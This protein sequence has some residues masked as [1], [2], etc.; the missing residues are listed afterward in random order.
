MSSPGILI[1][2]YAEREDAAKA[3]RLLRSSLFRR[4]RLLHRRADG[5]FD[6]DDRY[7]R[8]RFLAPTIGA[9]VGL[10][11]SLLSAATLL[12]GH[13]IP[14]TLLVVALVAIG[15]WIGRRH[16]LGLE[17]RIART[18][19]GSLVSWLLPEDTAI[20]VDA[21]AGD[22]AVAL[23]LMRSVAE[24]QPATFALLGGPPPALASDRHTA[25]YMSRAQLTEHARRLAD[26]HVVAAG[27][28]PTEPLLE[29]LRRADTSIETV[30]RRLADASQ[31]ELGLSTSAE[32][33]LD[34]AYIVQDHIEQVRRNLTKAFYHELPVLASPLTPEAERTGT[35]EV[36]RAFALAQA[37][38]DHTDALVDRDSVMAFLAAYQESS[39]LTIGE[40]WAMPLM[41]R[42][43]IVDRLEQ[44]AT[45]IDRRRHH[46][47]LAD[48]FANRLLV[49]ARHDPGHLFGVLT[50]MTRAVPEPSVSFGAQLTGHLYDEDAALLPVQ[51]WLERR[52]RGPLADL[53]GHEH[54]TEGAGQVSIGNA[55]TSLRNL[56]QMDW[57]H[58][59]EGLSAV[60]RELRSDP[61]REYAEM[62]FDTRNRY[63][64]VVE[65]MAA[66]SGTPEDEVARLAV[67]LAGEAGD[68]HDVNSRLRHVGTYLIGDGRTI[69]ADRVG[70]VEPA[71]IRFREALT[72]HHASFYVGAT[73]LSTVVFLVPVAVVLGRADG[74]LLPIAALLAASLPA[75]QLGVQ[76]VNYLIAL[77]MPPR[78]LPKMSFESGGIPDALRT[79]VVVP[80]ILADEASIVEE[81]AKLETRFLANPDPNLVYALFGDFAD[82]DAPHE[83]RTSACWGRPYPR[84]GHW[85]SDT[86]PVDSCT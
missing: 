77:I 14:A 85:T 45:D 68:G 24:V 1:G 86:G 5:S 37:L 39:A 76:V 51:T 81:V 35:A 48:L 36:P 17:V 28:S 52:L 11:A 73:A 46:L 59:F 38:V 47:E 41:L 29:R 44:L 67:Q 2:F 55:I 13:A 66:A 33:L 61:A 18:D 15:T 43:A 70:A 16:S 63:R 22:L 10:T 64:A 40:L 75:S 74:R 23:D 6:T 42:I 26:T 53:I 4:A 25:V 56:S 71:S 19:L 84:S 65:R 69:L 50:E 3:L 82:S 8:A 32:W 78:S 54:A 72:R 79:L 21:A 60:E 20:V 80:T 58:V 30:R 7:A 62:D 9:L 34:N 57:R 49:A 12:R 27:Q 31:L 83:P